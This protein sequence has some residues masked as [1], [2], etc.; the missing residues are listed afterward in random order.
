MTAEIETYAELL[1]QL[2]E[3]E[4]NEPDCECTQCGPDEFDPSTCD[5]HWGTSSWNREHS[6]ISGALERL[7]V[8]RKPA[9]FE[10]RSSQE[11]FA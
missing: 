3:L 4:S 7:R 11:A 10:V 2:A 6:R 1:E 5:F 8:P 9:A